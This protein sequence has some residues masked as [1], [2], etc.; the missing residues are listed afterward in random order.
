MENNRK[1]NAPIVSKDKLMEAAVYFGHKTSA[2][3]PKM[4][5]FIIG[6]K[7]G[8]HIIDINKTS[9]A[10]E[11]TYR[12]LRK[13]VD[14]GAEVIFVGTKRQAKETIRENALRTN[15]HY[16][17]ERW[18]GGILTNNR[19]IYGRVR[20][21]FELE[22]MAKNNF[23]GYTKKEGVLFTKELE[24]LQKNL[25]GIKNLRRRPSIMISADPKGDLIA[26]KEAKKLGIKTIGIVDSNIDPSIVDIAIPGNDD[27]KKSLTL[28][29]TILAD[30]IA[31]AKKGQQL[32]AYQS[33][34]KIVL[35][36]EEQKPRRFNNRRRNNGPQTSRFSK[37]NNRPAR[38]EA[39]KT[40]AKVE[41]KP[42]V[43][44]EAP[45]AE[46]AT[47]DI[48]KLKVAELKEMAKDK[49][50]KGISAMKKADLIAALS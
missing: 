9:K 43:K 49:G 38:T 25:S 19:T 47:T 27:S 30:A 21:M 24:K 29:I 23:A 11:Y 14:M 20:R 48:S 2:W 44:A 34:D 8:T 4:K 32:F 28:I 6:S 46:A 5:P 41:A 31:A 17:S 3:H 35:P 50:I 13:Y 10:L 16:V 39:P 7:E 40:E 37:P 22:E 12:I 33:D 1:N 42:E 36:Q 45:K 15:S 18:L 26:I